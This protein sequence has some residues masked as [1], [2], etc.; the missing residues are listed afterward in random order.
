MWEE[1]GCGTKIKKIEVEHPTFSA[2]KPYLLLSSPKSVAT[3]VSRRILRPIAPSP[4]RATS[5]RV[6]RLPHPAAAASSRHPPAPPSATSSHPSCLPPPPL[7]SPPKRLPPPHPSATD[8]GT[9]QDGELRGGTHRR[10]ALGGATLAFYYSKTILGWKFYE[11]SLQFSVIIYRPLRTV[12][13]EQKS[14]RLRCKKW[15]D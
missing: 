13:R 7:F 10:R 14:Q 5:S 1:L 11:K 12:S 8:R 4:P 9:A 3:T 15:K 2:P 6:S